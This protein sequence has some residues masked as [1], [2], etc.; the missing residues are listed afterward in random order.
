L[1][2]YAVFQFKHY[3]LT[4]LFDARLGGVRDSAAL[5]TVP[6][7]PENFIRTPLERPSFQCLA[8]DALAEA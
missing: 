7:D 1:G 5:T 3:Y 8:A 4:D 6:I 2:C